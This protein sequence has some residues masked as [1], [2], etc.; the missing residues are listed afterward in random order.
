MWSYVS[1]FI[2]LVRFW[3]QSI[4]L[5]VSVILSFFF[6]CWAVFQPYHIFSI[7]LLSCTSVP[8]SSSIFPVP[9]LESTIFPDSRGLSFYVNILFSFIEVLIGAF[10]NLFEGHWLGYRLISCNKEI[11]KYSGL[12]KNI[13]S[14]SLII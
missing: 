5:H 10:P 7:S 13:V 11:L 12:S 3:G 14:F 2:H 1:G 6:N 9:D 8:G 4:L